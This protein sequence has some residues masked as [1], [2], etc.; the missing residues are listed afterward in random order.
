MDAY[1]YIWYIYMVYI[2]GIYI[3]YIRTVNVGI[4]TPVPMKNMGCF[5]IGVM[6][7]MFV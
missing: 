3:W 2:Y 7:V 5:L 1:I 6:F 4:L